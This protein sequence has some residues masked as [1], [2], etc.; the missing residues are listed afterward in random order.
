MFSF[1]LWQARESDSRWGV[2]D[3]A[4]ASGTDGVYQ[5][6]NDRM[7]GLSFL[8]FRLFFRFAE[9]GLQEDYRQMKSY[10]LWKK[11]TEKGREMEAAH[12]WQAEAQHVRQ[13]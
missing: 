9:L 13:F 10:P 11:M 8:Y 6:Q 3:A 7:G 5:D 2:D 4:A 1:P 12:L